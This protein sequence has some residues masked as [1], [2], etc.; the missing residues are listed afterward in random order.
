MQIT[1]RQDDLSVE[2]ITNGFL[3]TMEGR[4]EENNWNTERFFVTNYEDLNFLMKNYF[5]LEK[6]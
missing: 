6:V 5:D 3:V 4:D 1:K 2:K